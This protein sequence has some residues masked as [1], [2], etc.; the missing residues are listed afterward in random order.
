MIPTYDPEVKVKAVGFTEALKIPVCASFK[1]LVCD[2]CLM[3]F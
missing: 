1:R 3:Q 2:I